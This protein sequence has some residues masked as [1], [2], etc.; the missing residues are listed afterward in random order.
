MFQRFLLGHNI[1]IHCNNTY[2]TLLHKHWFDSSR[3][4]FANTAKGDKGG[5][6]EYG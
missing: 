1:H 2:C 6:V 3:E 4:R 5:R